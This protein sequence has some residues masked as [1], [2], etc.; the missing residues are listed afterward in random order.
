MQTVLDI[1]GEPIDPVWAAEFRGFFMGEGSIMILNITRS[2]IL[3]STGEKERHLRPSAALCLRADNVEVLRG[4]QAKLG[5]ATDKFYQGKVILHP[6]GQ[7]YKAAPMVKWYT[8]ST[9][10][11]SRVLDLIENP[12]LPYPKAREIAIMREFLTLRPKTGK[13]LTPELREHLWKLKSDLQE[14]RKYIPVAA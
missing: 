3:K 8:H 12:I 4:I 7:A 11:V 6:E 13:K 14:I 1:H 9:D 2:R 5:G 10:G